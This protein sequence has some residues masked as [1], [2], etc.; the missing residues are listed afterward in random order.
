VCEILP[1]GAS[2]FVA[3]DINT[4]FPAGGFFLPAATA[5]FL[6]H[7]EVYHHTGVKKQQHHA[8]SS[9]DELRCMRRFVLSAVDR[10]S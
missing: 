2:L 10:F 5:L 3:P 6:C 9:D 1:P 7:V 8:F 4:D